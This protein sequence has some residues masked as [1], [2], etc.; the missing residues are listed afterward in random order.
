M[1]NFLPFPKLWLLDAVSVQQPQRP[2]T[3]YVY[4]SRG[5]LCSFERLMMGGVSSET[6][7]ALYKQEIRNFDTLLQFVGYFCMNYTMMHGSTNIKFKTASFVEG[8]DNI[9][10]ILHNAYQY[11][12]SNLNKK[13]NLNHFY[14]KFVIIVASCL[15]SST[16]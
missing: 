11:N 5:C 14:V 9:S 1:P 10:V 15:L 13:Q 3:F 6:C 7:W 2:T 8:P 4:K 12:L 16:Y